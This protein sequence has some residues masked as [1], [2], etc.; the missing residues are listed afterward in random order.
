MIL[1]KLNKIDLSNI[2]RDIVSQDIDD[3]RVFEQF[4]K[5]VWDKKYQY[6]V[7]DR[8]N[9]DV[10]WRYRKGFEIPYDEVK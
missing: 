6:M 7:I 9:E 2:Y 10:N 4:A 8:F 5:R 1:F 3:Y